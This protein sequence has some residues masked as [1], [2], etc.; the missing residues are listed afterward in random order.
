MIANVPYQKAA[1]K[2]LSTSKGK[3]LTRETPSYTKMYGWL[4]LANSKLSVPEEIE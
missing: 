3:T 1:K 2:V 4:L